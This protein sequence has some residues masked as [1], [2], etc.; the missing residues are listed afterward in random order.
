MPASDVASA[1]DEAHFQNLTIE[2]LVFLH[3]NKVMILIA[4]FD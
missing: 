2:T 1:P 4:K 3:F